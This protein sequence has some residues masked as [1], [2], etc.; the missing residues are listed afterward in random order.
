MGHPPD[1]DGLRLTELVAAISLATDLVTGQ[2]MEHALRTCR[3]SV[4]VA[5]QLALDAG[6]VADVHYVALLRFLGCTADAPEVAR[7]AGGDNLAFM[8][9]M[10]PVYMGSVSETVGTLARSAGR[11][12]SLSRRAHLL[13]EAVA[14]PRTEVS[15]CEVGARLAARLG[16]GAGVVEALA[17]AYERWDGRGLPDG[18]SGAEIPVAIRVVVVARDAVLWHR[19]AGPAAAM[20]VLTRRRGR[21]YDPAAVDAVRAVGIPVADDPAVWDEVLAGEP[22]PVLR[23]GAVGLDRALAAVGD[24]ADLRSTWTRGR[25][26]RL[27]ATARAAGRACGL[28]DSDIA[29]L[30]RAALVA[31]VGAV[32]V[33]SGVWERRG[34]LG[35]DES[36][37]M[38]L[39]SYLSE[40][41]VGRC[42]QLRPVAALAGAHHERL[43]GSGYHRGSRAQQLPS[44]A[45]LLAAADVW[46][47][48]REERP[49][50]PAFAPAAAHDVL[51]RES[52]EGG[53]DRTA[54]EAVLSADGQDASRPRVPRPAGL[55]ER[56]VEVLRLVARGLSNREV[57]RRLWISAKTVGHHVEHVYA[58]I[59]VTTRPAAALFAMEHDLLGEWG[60]HPMP[61][62]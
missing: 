51:W 35:V 43:D 57:A 34:P 19:M 39:H 8:A 41:V 32:G 49:H 38:R 14:N 6:T 25:S 54:V 26:S 10:S 56:E 48:L 12:S 5:N 50:R 42:P 40:R 18:L 62:R 44:A 46:T 15:H 21:A 27:A 17:H 47:A 59:G 60:D 9:A 3:L 36:E 30:A 29:T 23:V 22:A 37:R 28:P 2:P 33:P 13:A 55:S 31:D 4:T 1:G 45:R 53:L 16:L 58:K 24:F 52:A 11:G 61:P 20:D 7:L